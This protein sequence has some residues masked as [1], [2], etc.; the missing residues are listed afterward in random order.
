MSRGRELF[1]HWWACV[2]ICL[3]GI[4]SIFAGVSLRSPVA[5]RSYLSGETGTAGATVACFWAYMFLEC[6]FGHRVRRKALWILLFVFIPVFSAFAYFM[7]SRS[8]L[9]SSGESSKQSGTI[10]GASSPM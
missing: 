8:A 2:S 1:L 3:I 4:L 9:Y 10:T 6:V 5:L 7:T